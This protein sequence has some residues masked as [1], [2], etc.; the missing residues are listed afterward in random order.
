M[1]GIGLLIL[2]FV[3][4][5]GL[6]AWLS[7]RESHSIGLILPGLNVLMA[8]LLGMLNS[9]YFMGYMVYAMTMLPII[10]WLVIY[11]FFQRYYNDRL[12]SELDK[13]RIRDL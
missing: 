3:L 9:D 5:C 2:L 11:H 1:G 12:K 4:L 13:S 8:T 6:Q 10:V 7:F